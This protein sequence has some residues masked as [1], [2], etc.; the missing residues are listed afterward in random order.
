MKSYYDIL[1]VSPTASKEELKKSYYRL[2]WKFHPDKNPGNQLAE[3]RFKEIAEAYA[4]LIDQEKRGTYDFDLNRGYIKCDIS[5]EPRVRAESSTAY[6]YKT[7]GPS[8]EAKRAAQ[9]ENSRRAY[10]ERVGRAEE[11][12]KERLRTEQEGKR[13]NVANFLYTNSKSVVELTRRSVLEISLL[14]SATGASSYLTDLLF[15]NEKITAGYGVSALSLI[16]AVSTVYAS[17]KYFTER[18]V[19]AQERKG[20]E[21]RMRSFGGDF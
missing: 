17:L 6:H 9:R 14:G 16:L 21:D 10:E 19:L 4:V 12:A 1:E 15:E 13:W 8:E 3:E 5:T 2:V 11:L 18:R 20:L 7:T